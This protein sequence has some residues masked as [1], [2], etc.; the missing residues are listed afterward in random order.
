[1]RQS[2][3]SFSSV[4]I[5]SVT[6]ASSSRTRTTAWQSGAAVED[7]TAATQRDCHHGLLDASWEARAQGYRSAQPSGPASC[8]N[9]GSLCPPA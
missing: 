4:R 9:Q 1:V 3:G 8:T 2:S 6:S 7:I 5:C